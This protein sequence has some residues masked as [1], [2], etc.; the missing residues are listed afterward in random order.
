MRRLVLA[1]A[2]LAAAGALVAGCYDTSAVQRPTGAECGKGYYYDQYGYDSSPPQDDPA[3]A[4]EGDL[5]LILEAVQPNQQHMAGVC[6]KNCQ[7]ES[8]CNPNEGCV[9]VP[10]GTFC[11]R[12]CKTDDDCFDS[13]VCR[14]LH[15]GDTHKYCFVNP[16]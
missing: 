14:L 12:G 7:V 10:E 1:T 13:F 3:A 2:L 4:C 5:C 11:F 8:E 15:V 6:S 9:T 16:A